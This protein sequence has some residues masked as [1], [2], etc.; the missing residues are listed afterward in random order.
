MSAAQERKCAVGGPGSGRKPAS[1]TERQASQARCSVLSR[2][3]SQRYRA[4]HPEEVKDRNRKYHAEH[5]EEILARKRKA[6][7]QN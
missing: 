1:K 5:R 7:A 2:E 3:Y 6:K 4:R